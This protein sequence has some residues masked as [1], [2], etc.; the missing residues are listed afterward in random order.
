M[1]GEHLNEMREKENKRRF[2]PACAG[3]TCQRIPMQY[4]IGGSSPHARGT[5][6]YKSR[7]TD[8]DTVHPRMRGEHESHVTST[9]R[10]P[11][12]IPACAGNTRLLEPRPLFK[13]VHPRMRGEHNDI[14][15]N[16]C[17]NSGSS[18]HARGTHARHASG[19]IPDWF[20][21][22]C[23]GNTPYLH[24][25]QLSIAGSS[26]HARGTRFS[27]WSEGLRSAV[28]P[29]MRGEHFLDAQRLSA[30]IRFIPACAGNTKE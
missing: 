16:L 21:P 7:R 25:S 3:N 26:P 30:Y 20:I 23:A 15:L 1:R 8:G 18:P 9:V 14:V 2:I 12:F 4:I 17:A 13:R 19:Q 24:N 10:Y 5:R 28:H 22:A 29:R 11:R 6:Y 27:R